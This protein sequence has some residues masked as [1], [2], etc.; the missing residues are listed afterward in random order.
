MKRKTYWMS[1]IVGAMLLAAG[2]VNVANAGMG[3]FEDIYQ[4]FARQPIDNAPSVWR[5]DHPNGVSERELQADSAASLSEAWRMDKPVVASTRSE[6]RVAN[7]GGLTEQQYQS[8][9]SDGPA[10]HSSPRGAA[11]VA[12][13]GSGGMQDASNETL[14][15]RLAR[16]FNLKRDTQ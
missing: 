11:P 14:A 10:W 1:K 2:V 12:S 16:F 4:Y 3:R 13:N 6:F 7:P 9:S 15:A 8:L 5:K